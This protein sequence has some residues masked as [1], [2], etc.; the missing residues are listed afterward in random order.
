M[1]NYKDKLN[2]VC[3]KFNLKKLD[4]FG[5]AATSK[6]GPNS[7]IDFLVEFNDEHKV[8][9]F[10]KYFDLKDELHNIFQRSVDI[11]IEHSVR[12][13]FFKKRINKTRKPIY[14]RRN[15]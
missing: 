7:D 6:F 10:D 5:S 11:V 8:N 4:L 12:N 2:A 9:L 3:S 14:D 13:P 15:K 1:N